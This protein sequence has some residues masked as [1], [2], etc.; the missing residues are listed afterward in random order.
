MALGNAHRLASPNQNAAFYKSAEWLR[1]RQK[2]LERD[3][4]QCQVS[5]VLLTTGRK[6]HDA[7]VVDH[8]VPIS[9]DPSR[10]LDPTNLWSVSKRIHD[11]VCAS[12]ESR[13]KTAE[14]ITRA[15][16]SYREVGLDGYPAQPRRSP[17]IASLQ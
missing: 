14:D 4:W 5:G 11:Q 6:S 10:K 7:A 9:I 17:E 3:G 15:K 8:I 1:V 13:H 2:I 12:I 16:L